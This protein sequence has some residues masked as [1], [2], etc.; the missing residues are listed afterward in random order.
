MGFCCVVVIGFWLFG[1]CWGLFFVWGVFVAVFGCWGCFWRFPR[2]FQITPV[3]HV[4]ILF[5]SSCLPLLAMN[6]VCFLFN[7]GLQWF[8]G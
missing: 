5:I 3:F 7:Y 4:L 6:D 2:F 8:F 1:M